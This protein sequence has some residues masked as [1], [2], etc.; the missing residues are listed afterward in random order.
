MTFYRIELKS[1]IPPAASTSNN[2]NNVHETELAA[3]LPS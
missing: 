3:E 2:V 1:E